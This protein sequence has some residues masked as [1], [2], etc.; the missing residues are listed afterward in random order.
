[1]LYATT[2][3]ADDA[4]WCIDGAAFTGVLADELGGEAEANEKF[5]RYGR[6]FLDVCVTYS[7]RS[8]GRY[9]SIFLYALQSI[10]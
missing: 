6:K 8:Q 10:S 3:A 5:R 4:V 1:M 7:L 2:L 9:A